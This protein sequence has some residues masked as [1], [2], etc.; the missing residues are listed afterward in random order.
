MLGGT[1]QW[2]EKIRWKKQMQGRYS[3]HDYHL[4]PVL[5]PVVRFP[6]IKPPQIL[7]PNKNSENKFKLPLTT[8]ANGISKIRVP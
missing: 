5:L 3:L 4:N 2:K 1:Y 6:S 8:M 7:D